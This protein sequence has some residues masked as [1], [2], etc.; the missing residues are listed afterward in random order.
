MN[1]WPYCHRPD[2]V[3]ITEVGEL[4]FVMETWNLNR[5]AQMNFRIAHPTSVTITFSQV[6]DDPLVILSPLTIHRI[7]LLLSELVDN[8]G[9][10]VVFAGTNKMLRVVTP[11]K[12]PVG[13]VCFKRVDGTIF[14][15]IWLGTDS[16]VRMA[17][18]SRPFVVFE[19]HRR[20]VRS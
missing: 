17:K 4:E 20:D 2:N 1:C 18:L 13:S 11:G 8:G 7:P 16:E 5:F 6:R 10:T 3:L 12:F 19:H 15:Q 9:H 14:G